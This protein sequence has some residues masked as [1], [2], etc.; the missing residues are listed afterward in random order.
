MSGHTAEEIR[1]EVR[2]YW[3]VGLA[4][5]LLTIITV[6]VS[7]LHL[8][9]GMAVAIALIIACVKG[10]LVAGVFMHLISERQAVYALLLLTAVFFLFV[11]L[12]PLGGRLGGVGG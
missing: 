5:F 12:G 6:A 1:A 8:S 4:L 7:Y 2:R 11:M 3:L 9:A 10:G